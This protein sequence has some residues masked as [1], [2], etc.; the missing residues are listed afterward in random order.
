MPWS[1][2][3]IFIPLPAVE[4]VGPHSVG[5]PM[6]RGGRGGGEPS[7]S[8]RRQGNEQDSDSKQ[9][10]PVQE[11]NGTS[12]PMKFRKRT[13]GGRPSKNPAQN[14]H[15]AAHFVGY[16]P[17]PPPTR[18]AR[19]CTSRGSE[20]R[21]SPGY[22]VRPRGCGGIGR[23]ARFRSVWGKPRGGSSP[24]IRIAP[25]SRTFASS[26]VRL[27]PHSVRGRRSGVVRV[28]QPAQVLLRVRQQ[29]PVR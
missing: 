24:L 23:R 16:R 10:T 5:A 22:T 17:Q 3:P 28:K 9:K 13:G 6:S 27:S 8:R 18:G 25:L 4:S 11:R 2:I 12:G 26:S 21:R 1:M 7:G 19:V 29:V 15:S 14:W 20:G